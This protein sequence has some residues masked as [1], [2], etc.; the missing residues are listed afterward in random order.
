MLTRRD[1]LSD[2]WYARPGWSTTSRYLTWHL[3]PDEAPELHETVARYHRVLSALPGIDLVP[4]QWLHV[5]VQGVGFAD[6]VTETN[7]RAVTAAAAR[8]LTGM[9]AVE[10][11]FA[12]AAVHHEGVLLDAAPVEPVGALRSALRAA[13]A[14]V[15]SP[16]RVDGGDADPVWPHLSLAYAHAPVP[17]AP[18][19][20]AVASV[21][22][23]PV[24]VRFAHVSLIELRRAG[25]LYCW[26]PVAEV[27]L[28]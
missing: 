8:R 7:V 5:T 9:P 16:Q 23:A 17:A 27:P 25:R 1:R 4:P 19:L 26:D 3:L 20:D 6:D 12:P 22:A 24:L 2:H 15:Q 10:L 11:T 14:D 13:I 21:D 18:L 28:G